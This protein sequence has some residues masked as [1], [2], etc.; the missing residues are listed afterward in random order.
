MIKNQNNKSI[1]KTSNKWWNARPR[2]KQDS[3]IK[4]LRRL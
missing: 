4:R 2:T 1:V 3:H